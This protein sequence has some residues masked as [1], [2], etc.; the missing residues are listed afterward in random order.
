MTGTT[1]AYRTHDF[2]YR[3]YW[4]FSVTRSAQSATSGQVFIGGTRQSRCPQQG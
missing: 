2:G 3:G 1:F 4:R